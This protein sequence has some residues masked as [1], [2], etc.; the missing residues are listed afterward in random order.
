MLNPFH[1]THVICNHLSWLQSMEENFYRIS[2]GF[3]LVEQGPLSQFKTAHLLATTLR[4]IWPQVHVH[5][6]NL[7]QYV[8]ISTSSKSI[9]R[10]VNMFLRC[11]SIHGKATFVISI[12]YDM[13]EFQIDDIGGFYF[14]ILVNIFASFIITGQSECF[15]VYNKKNLSIRV[16]ML[17]H[18]TWNELIIQLF[19]KYINLYIIISMAKQ[20]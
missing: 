12:I 6:T 14:C 10:Q 8:D 2:S 19:K 20:R 5:Y 13:T 7:S 11:R 1:T 16:S 18:M 4:G 17:G 3:T 9:S 15:F